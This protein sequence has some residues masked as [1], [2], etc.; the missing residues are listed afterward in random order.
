MKV[1]CE[2]WQVRRNWGFECGCWCLDGGFL[3]GV[4]VAGW[5]DIGIR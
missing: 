5:L 2:G 4:W 1:R 3:S